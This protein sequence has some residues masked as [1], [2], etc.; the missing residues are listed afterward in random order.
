MSNGLRAITMDDIASAAGM[1]KKTVYEHFDSKKE[2]VR[3]IAQHLIDKLSAKVDAQ[4]D[5]HDNP[6]E[7]LSRAGAAIGQEFANVSPAYYRDLQKYYP[8]V[9][10]EVETAREQRFEELRGMLAAAQEQG[11][12]KGELNLDVTVAMYRASIQAVVQP[13]FLATHPITMDEAFDTIVEIFLR[14][15]KDA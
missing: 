8:D 3:A 13:A 1:S 10:A 14:G 4:F 11:L 7:G 2:L 9:W 15:V 12:V 6:L 5:H